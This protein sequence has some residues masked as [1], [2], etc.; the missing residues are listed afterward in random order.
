[1]R[2]MPITAPYGNTLAKKLGKSFNDAPLPSRE[3]Q[4][5]TYMYTANILI[6]TIGYIL[7]YHASQT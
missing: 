2:V 1:M 7:I 4:T 3:E 6:S 5:N